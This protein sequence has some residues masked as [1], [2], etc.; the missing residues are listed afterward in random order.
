MDVWR[1]N[2]VRCV[3]VWRV[4]VVHRSVWYKNMCGGLTL[5]GVWK[6]GGLMW[7]IDL[8]GIKICV[9]G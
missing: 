2:I 7:C 1:V 3:E 9:E 5:Y 8:C 6:Y 4:N